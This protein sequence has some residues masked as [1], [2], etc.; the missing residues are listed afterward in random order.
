MWRALRT[1]ILLIVLATVALGAWRAQSRAASWS[2]SLFVT[3]YPINA[4]G[5]AQTADY[6]ASLDKFD[7][8]VMQ[9]WFDEQARA[10]GIALFRPIQ[11]EVA[12]PRNS[13]PPPAPRNGSMLDNMLWS[14]QLRYWAWNNDATDGPAPDIRLF[15][16]FHTPGEQTRLDHSVGLQK[17]MIGVAN[18]FASRRAH[19]SNLVVLTHELMHTLGAS[20]KY[21]PATLQP[22]YPEGFAEPDRKQPYPQRLAEIMGGRIPVSD[23]QSQI[24]RRLADTVVG[25][26]SAMEIGWR[27]GS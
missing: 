16:Q 9:E 8:E 4:D 19:G 11:I 13:V 2:D 22:I 18:L 6:I 12:A 23:T 3:I 5:A 26:V 15:A 10:Y 27:E 25:P 7:Y 24:P 1:T 17:G 21:N 14:L 20:D